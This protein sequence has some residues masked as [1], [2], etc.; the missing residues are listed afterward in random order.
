MVLRWRCGILIF[1]TNNSRN[2]LLLLFE[3]FPFNFYLIRH[4]RWM[5]LVLNVCDD[6]VLRRDV[7]VEENFAFDLIGVAP[8]VSVNKIMQL[9]LWSATDS[10]LSLWLLVTM[11][12]I[13]LLALSMRKWKLVISCLHFFNWTISILCTQQPFD[14]KCEFKIK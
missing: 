9:S 8:H 4:F 5:H 13:C 6:D 7:S 11:M 12:L 14:D 1:N 10:S 3:T 2:V